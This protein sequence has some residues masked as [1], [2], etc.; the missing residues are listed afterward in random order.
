MTVNILHSSIARLFDACLTNG[1][2]RRMSGQRVFQI[3]RN[4]ENSHTDLNTQTGKNGIGD[5]III[6]L[7]CLINE[8]G[9]MLEKVVTD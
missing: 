9:K 4:L 3:S 5:T 2:A 6:R 7:I 8:I 1:F